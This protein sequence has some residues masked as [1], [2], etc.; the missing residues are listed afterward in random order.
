MVALQRV[1]SS[2][3]TRSA[4]G[5]FDALRDAKALIGRIYDAALDESQW[6]AVLVDLAS[7]MNCQQSNLVMIDPAVGTINVLTP[8]WDAALRD[9]FF[10]H[11]QKQ[12]SLAKRTEHLPVGK[13][14]TYADLIDLEWFRTTAMY[15]EFWRP[16]GVGGGSLGANL[17]CDGH[18][19]SLV[20]VHAALG[21]DPFSH[22]ERQVFADVLPHLVR[23]ITI[24][25]KLQLAEAR[26]GAKQSNL[27][28]GFSIVD[29]LGRVIDG[30]AATLSELAEVGVL[31]ADRSIGRI[32][33]RDGN[34]ERAIASSALG[35][36]A[37]TVHL[38]AEDG[39]HLNIMVVPIA[40]C[41]RIEMRTVIIDRPAALLYLSRPDER[42]KLQAAWLKRL[43][44]LTPGEA[45]V[46]LEVAK[47]DGRSAVAR[48]LGIRETTVRS[49]LTAIF[50]KMGIHR[51]AELVRVLSGF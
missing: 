49:H 26:A 12:F 41:D 16:Q 32:E 11:W 48:R 44:N 3:D 42:R 45:N 50:E 18:A 24:Q 34:L 51:Q 9:D 15:N 43:Y 27:P 33:T 37:A 13:V 10:S 28:S 46:A 25:R 7:A 30:D 35:R 2:R 5:R 29:R 31:A 4:G 23:A 40:E 36:G 1:I 38:R 20:T 19:T 17:I 39:E 47:G 21:R 14:F 8:H 6:P 22:A